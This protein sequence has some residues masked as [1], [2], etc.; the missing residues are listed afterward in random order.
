MTFLIDGE[1]RVAPAGSFVFVP[2]GV[3]HTFWNAGTEPARQL[4]VFTPSGI[5]DFF[6]A[7]V[8]V[9]A[10]G[11]EET[12]E[13][14]IALSERHDMIVP[15]TDRPPYGSLDEVAPIAVV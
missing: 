2:R 14:I 3:L 12:A 15:P 1:E 10:E 4:T 7:L 8:P 6:D 9:L 11:G 5:E 13:A